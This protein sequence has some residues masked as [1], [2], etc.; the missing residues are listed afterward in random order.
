MSTKTGKEWKI[1]YWDSE[2]ATPAWDDLGGFFLPASIRVE[3]REVLEPRLGTRKLAFAEIVEALPVV[4]GTMKLSDATWLTE[5]AIESAE[6]GLTKFNYK[7]TDGQTIYDFTNALVDRVEISVEFG[8]PI[9]AA[10]RLLGKSLTKGAT[11]ISWVDPPEAIF[12]WKNL[13]LTIGGVSITNWS[14]VTCEINNRVTPLY[15][16]TGITPQD[17]TEDAPEYRLRVDRAYAQDSKADEV[18]AG[19]K[20]RI[21]LAFGGKTLTFSNCI[22]NRNEVSIP[23]LNWIWETIEARAKSLTVA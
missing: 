13:S 6:G 18:L 5:K 3:G 16:G 20:E 17:L 22:Y 19:T 2:L 21:V 8:S 4:E 10:L 9:Q 12:T 14:R 7:L 1:N 23:D 15:V 11:S